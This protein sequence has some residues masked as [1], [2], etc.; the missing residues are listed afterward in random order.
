MTPRQQLTH[1]ILQSLPDPQPTLEQANREWWVN[2]RRNGGYRLTIEGY[3]VLASVLDL[4][5]WRVPVPRL[6]LANVLVLD[7]K[8]EN[9]YFLDVRRGD[10]WLFGDREAMMAIMYGD[11]GQ[12]FKSLTRK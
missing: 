1:K 8:I 4:E 5:H 11:V 12:W 3:R 2:Q 10:L 6:S 7:Q 9:P